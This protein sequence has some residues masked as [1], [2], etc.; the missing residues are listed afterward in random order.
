MECGQSQNKGV[1]GPYE[2]EQDEQEQDEQEQGY[3]FF[4]DSI[5]GPPP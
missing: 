1:K 4:S 2:Q 3:D 5:Y